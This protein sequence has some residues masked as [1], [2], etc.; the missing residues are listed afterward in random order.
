MSSEDLFQRQVLSVRELTERLELL[1]QT[2]FDLVW[3][4][5]EISNLRQPASGHYY[6]ILKDESA[7][8][9]AVMFRNQ[10]RYLGFQPSDGQEVLVRGRLS[11]YAP[12]GEYQIVA[13]YM[14][15][16]GEGALRLAFE[17]L[18]ARLAAE[19]LFDEARK[20]RLPFLP[21]KVALVT[22]PTGAAIRDFIRVAQR[23][24]ERAAL[25]IYPVR[26][27]GQG[28]AEDIVQALADLNRAG[29]GFDLI[30]LTRGGGSLED[31]WAFNEEMVARAVFASSIPVVSAV[32]HEIDFTIADLVADLRAPTPSAAAELIF[33]EERELRSHLK[34]TWDRLGSILRG[35]LHLARERLAH[36]RTRLGD[37][38]R[39]MAGPRLRLDE[40]AEDLIKEARATLAWR[41]QV[42]AAGAGRLAPL[43]P[44]IRLAINRTSLAALNKDLVRTI[45]LSQSCRRDSLARLAGRLG[46]LSPLAV[47]QR[48]YALA[49]RRPD[50]KTVRSPEDVSVGQRVNLLLAGGE[51][52][53]I[54]DEVLG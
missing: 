11:I 44:K 39:V 23:R 25:F 45:R 27:Q 9:R 28:A 36:L 42:V 17:K 32:G 24:F 31:L 14:E 49:R 29:G 2:E 6:F 19:G 35:R 46:D 21:K 10:Q 30:V 8:I 16:R 22:S 50:L 4:I 52:D 33:R 1:I 26:V 40:M 41:R 18:K 5:G 47:L 7:Q 53:V 37:P 54:V 34:A 51:L 12:R 20:R 43:N 48:G 3:L 38:R 13:D 15:P